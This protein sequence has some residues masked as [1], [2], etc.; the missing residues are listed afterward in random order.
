[1]VN[2]LAKFPLFIDTRLGL[3]VGVI[4]ILTLTMLVT[5]ISYLSRINNRMKGIIELGN[6]KTELAGNMRNALRERALALYNISEI[7]DAFV[8]DE[9][10]QRFYGYGT[11][12]YQASE[13]MAELAVTA[14]EKSILNKISELTRI[15]QITVRK[16]VLLL[17]KGGDANDVSFIRERILPT[18]KKTNDQVDK[19][20]TLEKKLVS[21]AL[22]DAEMDYVNTSRLMLVVGSAYS[23]LVLLYSV[24]VSRKVSKQA[25]ELER[26]A[27]HDGLTKLPNRALFMD[28]LEQAI[29]RSGR[30]NSNFAILLLD[31]DRFKEINDTLGHAV[32]DQLLVEVSNRLRDNLRE[33]DTVARFGG[34]EFVILL[35]LLN[36]QHVPA[37]AEKLLKALEHPFKLAGQLVDVSASVG[38]AYFPLHGEDSLTLI[39]KADVAM[40]A[41]KRIQ[42]GI[43]V[44]SGGQEQSGKADLAFRSELLNA[45]KH[46]ELVLYFQPKIDLRSN[47]VSGVEALVRWQHP[48]RGFLA[49]DMFIPLAEQNGL[50]D[51]LTIWVLKKALQQCSVFSNEGID[52]SVAVNFSARSLHDLR[53]PGEVARMLSD[54]KVNPARLLI[55]IT[56]SAVMA[57]QEEALEVLQILDSMGV[58]LSIDDFGT[59]YSS[60]L[61]LTKLPVDEIKIDKSFV[62]GMILDE[63]AAAIVHS[64]IDLGHNLGKKVVAEGVET[65]EMLNMLKKWGC[66][67]AQGYYMSKPL[68]AD[69]L[70]LWLHES[71]WKITN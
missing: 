44:Y 70:M 23:V 3:S 48:Q 41:A 54:A 20:I 64:T 22:K 65:L 2:K 52:I 9:E 39:Q 8:K 63:Q 53:L 28:R 10:L 33:S 51:Q 49:P 66:D 42:A 58:T 38:V 57:D 71:D 5:G 61:Y 59:G 14:E 26:Q 56:E 43:A 12:Y 16:D 35:E 15:T 21:S 36:L 6:V 45:I 31:L 18:Q 47:T 55:E 37:L 40:Y 46:D 32:G 27:F 7:K 30:E 4:V 13:R 25:K 19:L 69:K 34:D 67:T 62:M 60:L 1:M 29:T 68:P 17:F 24:L 11:Q 50:I